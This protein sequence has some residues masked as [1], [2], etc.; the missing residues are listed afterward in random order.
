MNEFLLGIAAFLMLNLGVGL[1][2]LGRGPTAV[3]RLLSLL[4]FSSITVTILIL[5]AYAQAT[6]ELLA[7]ALILASL[8]T[9]AAI[10]FID[11]SNPEHNTANGPD[12]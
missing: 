8:A 9:I 3:D 10:A 12:S 2:R 11:L 1:I 6:K 4:L 5:L 7:V